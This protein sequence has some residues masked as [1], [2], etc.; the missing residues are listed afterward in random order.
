MQ[1]YFFIFQLTKKLSSQLIHYLYLPCWLLEASPAPHRV[2]QIQILALSPLG[3]GKSA[4]ANPELLM[5]ET[6]DF[7]SQF[8]HATYVKR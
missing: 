7:S 8:P 2:C 6:V 5:T 3:T 1:R 4:S